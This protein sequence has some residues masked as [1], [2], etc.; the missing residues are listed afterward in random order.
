KRFEERLNTLERQQLPFARSLAA[1][2]AAY[3][4]HLTIRKALPFFF[5]QPTPYTISGVRY[6]KGNKTSPA[7]EVYI[8]ND[9]GKGTPVVD[10][11]RHHF[12][13]LTRVQRRSERVLE[14]AGI[15]GRDEGW[16]PAAGVRLNRYGNVP[17]AEMT[18][19]LSQVAAFS[20]SGF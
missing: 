5:E 18:R 14:R 6:R 17:G 9:R 12:R 3:F 10:V 20:E 4:T 19:I 1:N 15:I 7:A 13:G 2:E 8:T 11:L 16:V